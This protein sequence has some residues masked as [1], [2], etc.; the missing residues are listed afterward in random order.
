MYNALYER[1][2]VKCARKKKNSAD[3]ILIYFSDYLGKIR[4]NINNLSCAEFA[5][6]VINVNIETTVTIAMNPYT[7]HPKEV[8]Y[9]F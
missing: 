8:L 6:R 1:F 4:K 5:Q 2:N 7:S 9:I 3:D